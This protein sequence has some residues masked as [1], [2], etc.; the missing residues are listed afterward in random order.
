VKNIKT[1]AKH[2]MATKH[3]QNTRSKHKMATKEQAA[4]KKFFD[5]LTLKCTAEFGGLGGPKV[6]K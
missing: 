1:Q 3:K 5:E 2:K 6:I 4:Y